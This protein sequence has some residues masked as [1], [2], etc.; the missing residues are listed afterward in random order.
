MELIATASTAL[1]SLSQS[2]ECQRMAVATSIRKPRPA[3]RAQYNQQAGIMLICVL[4]I[5][6][7][8][9]RFLENDDCY[10]GTLEASRDAQCDQD[11][12]LYWLLSTLVSVLG[13]AI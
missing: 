1:D 9:E 3:E 12:F 8:N 4:S 10:L 11:D 5:I 2:I 6:V 13:S 7:T